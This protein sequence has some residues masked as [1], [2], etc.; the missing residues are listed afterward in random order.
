MKTYGIFT[1]SCILISMTYDGQPKHT[2]RIVLKRH[3]VTLDDAM[4]MTVEH[5]AI[6]SGQSGDYDYQWQAEAVN[7]T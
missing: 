3:C 4:K 1:I 6:V 2:A 5:K 7:L